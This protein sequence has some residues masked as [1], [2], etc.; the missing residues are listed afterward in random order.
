MENV[1]FP[2]AVK[3]A[4]PTLL[5]EFVAECTKYDPLMSTPPVLGTLRSIPLPKP[6]WSVDAL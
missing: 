3:T 6:N 5:V 4:V 1:T 2:S